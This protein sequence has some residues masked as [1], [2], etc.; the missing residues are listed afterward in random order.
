MLKTKL[1]TGFLAAATIFSTLA[2]PSAPATANPYTPRQY[3]GNW[4]KHSTYT[5]YYRNYY[6]K[7]SPTYDGYKHHYVIYYPSRP[8]YYYYYN[9]QSK[10]YWGRCPVDTKGKGVYS[11][12]AE[13]DRKEKL[14]DIPEA[15]FPEPGKLPSIPEATDDATL[16]LPPD[17]LP[18]GE[19]LPPEKEKAKDK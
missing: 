11:M 17:D 15:A 3:Y 8:K 9:P 5:Y 12:L 13:K 2:L 7:P 6:Y 1:M 4:H 16:D 18:G 14:E 10:Q 19:A